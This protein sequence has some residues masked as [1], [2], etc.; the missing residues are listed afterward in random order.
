[1]ENQFGLDGYRVRV[2]T[3]LMIQTTL[4][5]FGYVLV[6]STGTVFG[7]HNSATVG[8]NPQ[9]KQGSGEVTE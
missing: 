3:A 9:C 2:A 1:M 4:T 8:C 6:G 5:R 7:L